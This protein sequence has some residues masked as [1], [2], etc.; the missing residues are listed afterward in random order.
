MTDTGPI[1]LPAFLQGSDP[2]A[3]VPVDAVDNVL[4]AIR[5]RRVSTDTINTVEKIETHE[6]IPPG[7][8][9]RL[10]NIERQLK[11]LMENAA[12]RDNLGEALGALKTVSKSLATLNDQNT[13]RIDE[14]DET[15][16]GL[17][18]MAKHL[19]GLIESL[20]SEAA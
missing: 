1:E 7:F 3:D 6:V 13:R 16:D 5:K 10:R 9:E 8:E 18:P 12:A 2:I 11:A 14:L 17:R 20:P 19:R 4:E 15:V